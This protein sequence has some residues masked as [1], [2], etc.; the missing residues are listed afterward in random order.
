MLACRVVVGK[1]LIRRRDD[2][3]LTEPPSKYHSVIGKPGENL[4][5]H[6]TIVYDN[7]AIRPAFLIVYGEKQ[8]EEES[9]CVVC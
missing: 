9:S 7:D 8:P 4:N 6:E 1:P 5:Y 2:P 3:K